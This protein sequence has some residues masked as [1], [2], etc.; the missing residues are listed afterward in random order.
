MLEGEVLMVIGIVG[1]KETKEVA[2]I[3]WAVGFLRLMVSA[4]SS[5]SEGSESGAA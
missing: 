1:M 3:N 2:E 4:P 5:P